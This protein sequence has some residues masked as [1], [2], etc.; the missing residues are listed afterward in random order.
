[1][2]SSLKL[3]GHMYQFSGTTECSTLFQCFFNILFS[4]I[5][6]KSS[7]NPSDTFNKSRNKA[8]NRRQAIGSRNQQ[9]GIV[10]YQLTPGPHGIEE[11]PNV[12][13][14]PDIA[15]KRPSAC[16]IA[17]WQ[18]LSSKANRRSGNAK[19]LLTSKPI[20]DGLYSC[21]VHPSSAWLLFCIYR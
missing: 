16:G 13:N 17:F 6:R 15:P 21:L 2:S 3:W 18:C 4:F 1:M 14:E 5:P 7:N 12:S 19:G 9:S 8:N 10:G 20:W 11:G